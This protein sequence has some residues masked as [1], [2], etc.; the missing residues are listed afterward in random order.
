MA[1]THQKHNSIKLLNEKNK[2]KKEYEKPIVT[3]N[4]NFLRPTTNK[5][6]PNVYPYHKIIPTFQKL[7]PHS[8]NLLITLRNV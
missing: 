5:I 6:Q 8:K 2:L 3:D 1:P 4:Q 7:F